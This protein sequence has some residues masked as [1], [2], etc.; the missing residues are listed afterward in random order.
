[1]WEQHFG[2]SQRSTGQHS[3]RALL[4]DLESVECPAPT[5]SVPLR[6]VQFRGH[7]ELPAAWSERGQL[8]FSFSAWS[9]GPALF[10]PPSD[11]G[12]AQLLV[13]G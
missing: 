6:Q 8:T 10:I 9:S 11:A 13:G 7:Q 3:V 2:V 1:M 12:C 4:H 5:S